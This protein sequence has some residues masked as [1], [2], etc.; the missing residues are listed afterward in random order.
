[1]SYSLKRKDKILAKEKEIEFFEELKKITSLAYFYDFLINLKYRQLSTKD[2]DVTI[3]LKNFLQTKIKE[4]INKYIQAYLEYNLELAKIK[5]TLKLKNNVD[6]LLKE[7]PLKKL[8]EKYNTKKFWIASLTYPEFGKKYQQRQKELRE[9][10]AHAKSLIASKLYNYRMAILKETRD[11]LLEV[12]KLWLEYE[13]YLHCAQFIKINQ[14]VF[15]DRFFTTPVINSGT[16]RNAFALIKVMEQTIDQTQA[17]LQNQTET[18]SELVNLQQN[19]A[20]L[21]QNLVSLQQEV[22]NL[23]IS[24]NTAVKQTKK[25]LNYFKQ[26][27]LSKAKKMQT[28]YKTLLQE[29]D[30]I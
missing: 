11:L 1:M 5:E 14:K 4:Q 26:F 29:L 21:K 30:Q 15:S 20:Q 12:Y 7:F 6:D 28:K 10:K 13:V 25:F 19:L 23:S 17:S 24:K 8:I 27:L 3:K 22:K 2:K 18:N 16:T 9:K